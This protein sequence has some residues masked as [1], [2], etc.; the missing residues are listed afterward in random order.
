VLA[1]RRGGAAVNSFTV[2]YILS[3]VTPVGTTLTNDVGV[4]RTLNECQ[5]AAQRAIAAGP[6][7]AV[8]WR[9]HEMTV[10]VDPT[11][12]VTVGFPQN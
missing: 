5:H 2:W 4:Y 3:I 1:E 6:D 10:A 12:L 8:R 11:G 7:G 9:C